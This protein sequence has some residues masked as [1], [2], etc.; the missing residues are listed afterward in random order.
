[1]TVSEVQPDQVLEI[2]RDSCPSYEWPEFARAH[3]LDEYGVLAKPELSRKSRQL[4]FF[5]KH[6]SILPFT[7][8]RTARYRANCEARWLWE[9]GAPVLALVA[10]QTIPPNQPLVRQFAGSHTN[11]R[12]ANRYYSMNLE[13][14]VAFN[15]STHQKVGFCQHCSDRDVIDDDGTADPDFEYPL[16]TSTRDMELLWKLE[17]KQQV[18]DM[19]DESIDILMKETTYR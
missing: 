13:H 2:A 3:D 8:H 7:Y 17:A 15:P 10:I 18:Y 12:C 11:S 6:G 4:Y 9:N 14:I 19:V 5:N 1:M 16:P